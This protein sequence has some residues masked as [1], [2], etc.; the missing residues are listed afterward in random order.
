MTT[1]CFNKEGIKNTHLELLFL[2]VLAL[3]NASRTGL[4]C[5]ISLTNKHQY[6]IRSSPFS[7]QHDEH[8]P[9]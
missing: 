2:T 6:G 9:N 7:R 4:D 1:T 8:V 3:P 5:K